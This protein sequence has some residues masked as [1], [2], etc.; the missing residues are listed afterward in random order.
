M[1]LKIWI[2][3][4]VALTEKA[5]IELIDTRTILPYYFYTE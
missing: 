5:V 1:G 4:L 2:L 3:M